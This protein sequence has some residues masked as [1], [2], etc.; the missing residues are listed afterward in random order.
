MDI[1]QRLAQLRQQQKTLA[2]SFAPTPAAAVRPDVTGWRGRK[3]E[4]D[5]PDVAEFITD[6]EDLSTLRSLVCLHVDYSAQERSAK[7]A[8]K[9]VIESLKSICNDYKLG[10]VLCDRNKISYFKTTRETISKQLLLD[11]GVSLVTILKCTV[12]SE[13]YS[14]R[15]TPPGQDDDDTAD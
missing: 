8:K 12:R 10:K 4:P 2:P 9:P 5:P 11:A 3:T 7:H 1:K 13:S 6:R 14:V 15:V